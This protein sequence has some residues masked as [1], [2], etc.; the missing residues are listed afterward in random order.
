MAN[1]QISQERLAEDEFLFLLESSLKSIPFNVIIATLLV[2]D[3]FYHN[4]PR[5]L[6]AFWF[7]SILLISGIRLF[8]S[9]YLL[10]NNR[11]KDNITAHLNAFVALTLLM[12]IAW[13]VSYYFFSAHVGEIQEVVIILV[14][15]GM[16]AGAIASLSVHLPAYCAYVIPMFLPVI[17]HNF[18]TYHF[19]RSILA[20]MTLLFVAMLIISAKI[21]SHLLKNTFILSNEKDKL[22]GEL[23][24]TNQMLQNSFEEIK[25]MSI[26]DAL[27]GLYNRRHFNAAFKSEFKRAKRHGY[28]LNLVLIDVDNFKYINDT[29]GHPS[30]DSFLIHIADSLKNSLPQE[31]DAIF[32]LGGDEFAAILSNIS[33]DEAITVCSDIQ[34]QFKDN[35]HQ[36]K[37]TLSMGVIYIPSS[38]TS[39]LEHLISTA[40]KTLYEAKKLGKNQ[41][42][43][44]NITH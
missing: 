25:V 30:G 36:D 35:I 20:V 39:D 2:V 26:T 40:D 5:A 42:I 13:G 11:F 12:G 14:L 44:K 17:L 16:S 28:P 33:L 4:A 43:S 19:D 23:K 21:N 6:M 8:Y 29:F 32:R 34:E 10:A 24:K 27:T 31:K 9:R 22:I 37:V 38:D 7:S 41:I 1:K 3:L 18:L 15:G